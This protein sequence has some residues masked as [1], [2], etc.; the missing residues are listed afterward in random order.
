MVIQLAPETDIAENLAAVK[1]RIAEA[2]EAAGRS[3]DAVT[4]VAVG[5]AHPA[6]HVRRALE[7][8]HRV[9]GENRID[10]AE[11]KWPELKA[12]YPDVRLH[13]IGPLQRN[14]VRRALELFDVI[15]SVDRPRLARAL[16]EEMDRNGHRADCFIQVNT[17]EEPQKSGIHP[18]EADQFIG[19]CRDDLGL[20][21][22]GLMCIPP[23]DDEP[24]LH[25]ALLRE[26]ARRNGL[27]D[28][29]M[30]MTADFDVAVR[31]GATHVRVGTAL[32]GARPPFNRDRG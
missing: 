9:F 27:G 28:L 8:G 31:F 29:S 4:L 18:A 7:A 23:Q 30:G 5:K 15:E 12:A 13:L 19:A 1:A 21:V 10:E 25:F 17:G 2:A 14:K 26:I 32:F 22:R 6:G 24:S 16:A 20:P 3:P 11:A